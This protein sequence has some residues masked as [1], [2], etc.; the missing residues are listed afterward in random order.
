MGC[1]EISTTTVEMDTAMDA[2]NGDEI[3]KTAVEMTNCQDPS[4][5]RPRHA[6]S[7]D[8]RSFYAS[9]RFSSRS[10]DAYEKRRD[11]PRKDKDRS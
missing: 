7:Y 10:R 5:W 1:A 4:L 2:E 3:A 9:F 8:R 6:Y 11:L